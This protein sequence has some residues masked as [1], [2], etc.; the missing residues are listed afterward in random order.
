MSNGKLTH[1]EEWLLRYLPAGYRAE[2]YF[3][4]WNLFK[5]NEEIRSM[6]G[7]R[8]EVLKLARLH[9]AGKRLPYRYSR[10]Y[11]KDID[12]GKSCWWARLTCFLRLG[13]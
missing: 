12:N 9:Q 13:V 10:G 6:I 2:R 1:D 8:W 7:N 11:W 4:R 5:D 3:G